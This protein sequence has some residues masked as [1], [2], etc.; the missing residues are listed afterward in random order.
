MSD[1]VVHFPH[2]VDLPIFPLPDTV[3]F[4]RTLLPLHIF[5]SRYRQ[6][7]ADALRGERKIGITLLQPGWEETYYEDPEVFD[8]GGMGLISECQELDEGKFNIL[9]SGHQRYRIVDF[10]GGDSSPYRMARVLLLDDVIPSSHDVREVATELLLL[11]RELNDEKTSPEYDLDVLEQLDFSTLVN[12][13]CSTVNLSV[14]DKQLLLEMS[15]VKERAETVLDVLKRQVRRKRL[16]GR[17]QHLK[18]DDP[19]LN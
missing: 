16:L 7:V 18:P 11:F 17:F 10:M 19:R 6:M 1:D 12:S 3:L 5:E 9:L 14:Y 15:A 2:Y 13:V 4:P 8:T